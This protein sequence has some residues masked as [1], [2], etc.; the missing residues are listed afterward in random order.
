[1]DK[2]DYN[3]VVDRIGYFRN[4]AHMSA[5]ELSLRLGYSE[6]FIKRIE[7]KQVELKVSTLLDICCILDIDI[8]DFFYLGIDFS[9]DDKNA[10]DDFKQLSSKNKELVLE[11]MGKLK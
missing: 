11:L 9:K 8:R 10:L 6:Q 7:S 5:R 1:M 3:E 2:I 4:K